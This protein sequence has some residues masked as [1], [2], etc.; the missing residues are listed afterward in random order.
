MP[1]SCETSPCKLNATTG[2]ANPTATEVVRC[3]RTSGYVEGVVMETKLRSGAR[4][5]NLTM[6]RTI[7]SAI[8]L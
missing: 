7:I 5:E 8:H 4:V 6:G 3:K 1:Q 2:G